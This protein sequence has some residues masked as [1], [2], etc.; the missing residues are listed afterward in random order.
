MF[1]DNK[2]SCIVQQTWSFQLHIFLSTYELLLPPAIKVLKG[3]HRYIMPV[4]MRMT[5]FLASKSQKKSL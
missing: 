4:T 2:R 3:C 5:W 1:V